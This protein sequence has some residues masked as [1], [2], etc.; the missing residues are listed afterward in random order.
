MAK[1]GNHSTLGGERSDAI[2][3]CLSAIARL[4]NEVQDASSFIPAYDQRTYAEA[5]K[6]LNTKLAEV[7]SAHA[8]KA[9]FSFKS[10]TGPIFNAGK[11]E[12]AISL[13]DAAN[14]AGQQRL[15]AP[16][17][18]SDKSNG[19][20]LTTTP[21]EPAASTPNLQP[22][23][24]TSEPQAGAGANTSRTQSLPVPGGSR[25]RMPSFSD[26]KAVSISDHED[27]HVV[28]PT[29]ASHATSSG[30][31]S[32]IHHCVVDLSQPASDSPFA[33]LILK[34]ISSS[35]I[36]CGHVS[37]SIHMTNVKDSVIVVAARQFRMHDSTSTSVY[38]LCNS[39]PIIEDCTTIQFA[40]IPQAYMAGDDKDLENQ[41]N[42]VDDFKWLQR[43]QS[44]HWSVLDPAKRVSEKVW[45][46]TVPGGPE[47]GIGDVLDAVSVPKA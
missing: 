24:Q 44:P 35:L 5:I 33:Q 47:V 23:D 11:N 31:V 3:H 19:S 15:N 9:K 8:P 36:I 12:S 34:N 26:S 2:D 25:Y 38:L 21:A 6:A 46:D 28:L 18:F 17:H 42:N 20:S 16:T 14:I 32:N 39:R 37:G 10:K 40:P 30:T 43:E 27:I 7:R 29:S 4:S 41:W 45:K 22:I 13:T 1:I